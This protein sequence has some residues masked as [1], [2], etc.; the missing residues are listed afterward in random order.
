MVRLVPTRRYGAGLGRAGGFTLVELMVTVAV[1]AIVGAIAAPA[2]ANMVRHNRLVSSSNEM[3]AALQLARA[4]AL[5]RRS[6]GTLCASRDGTTCSGAA[7]SQWIVISTKN[8]VPTTLRSVTVNPALRVVPS[9]N[10]AGTVRFDF[11]PGGF[12]QVGAATSG[13]ISLCASDLS[14]NNAMDVSAAV[15]RIASARRAA[16]A[17]CSA[18]GDL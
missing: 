12:V 18:P 4:E 10:L 15:V 3:I 16:G 14:G 17:G 9:A 7:G 2:F 11:S 8:G 13:T 1:V 5:A 6:T